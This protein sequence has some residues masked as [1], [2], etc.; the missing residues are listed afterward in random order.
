MI[1]GGLLLTLKL[2]AFGEVGNQMQNI[3]G[4]LCICGS[5]LFSFYKRYN[6]ITN[7]IYFKLKSLF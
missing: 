6:K 2:E 1:S 3:Q 7:D 4:A 5:Q